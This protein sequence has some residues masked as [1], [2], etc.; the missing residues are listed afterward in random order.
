MRV[1]QII[2]ELE[3]GGAERTTVDVAAALIAAGH[4]AHVA[5]ARGRLIDA[6]NT[7]GAMVHTLPVDRKSPMV[8][9]RTATQLA[10]LIRREG[11]DIVHAR[12]RACAWPALWAARWTGT[13]FVTTYH[14]IYN[15]KSGLKRWYN[16][17]MARGDIV[18][19]NSQ[20]TADHLID[21]HGTDPG[22]VRVIPRGVDLATFDPARVTPERVAALRTAWGLPDQPGFVILCPGRLTRW[23]G[24]TT[25]IEA[26][27]ALPWPFTLVLVGSAQGRT[28]FEAELKAQ[29]D[30]L[31]LQDRV[32]IVGHCDDMAAAYALADVVVC[33]SL[34][35]EAFGRTAAEAGA[36][37]K[38]VIASAHGGALEVIAHGKTGF[39]IPPGDVLLTTKTLDAVHTMPLNSR[40]EMGHSARMRIEEQ[41]SLA[42]MTDKTLSVYTEL[43]PR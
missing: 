2:P 40:A 29:I 21:A 10:R 15:A 16:G 4:S 42:Q 18:I 8:I 7:M 38:P 43:N 24:Q 6:L 28:A 5:T 13:P 20:Y 23:K 34:E 19:A 41:F 12:S 36:M 37:G 25:L 33:P 31:G 14:G 39:L 27:A 9:L 30:R 22:R 17:V 26:V 32:H 35:P 3:T 1:L 11:V